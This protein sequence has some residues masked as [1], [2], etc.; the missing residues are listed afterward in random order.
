M[1]REDVDVL[2]LTET[3]DIVLTMLELCCRK[4]ETGKPVPPP[5]CYQDPKLGPCI[6]AVFEV[7]SNADD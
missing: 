2:M 3:R 7:S 6:E 4:S 5:D 1:E